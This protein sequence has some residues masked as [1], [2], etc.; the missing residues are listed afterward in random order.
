MIALMDQLLKRV[1]LDL[2]LRPYV[3]LATGADDGII[4][5]VTNSTPVSGV[6]AKFN[7]SILAYL[8]HHNPDPEGPYGVTP[9]CMSTFVKSCAGYCVITYILGVGDRH[10]DNIMLQTAGNLFHLDFGFIFGR[11][12]KPLPP[13]FRRRAIH[14][15]MWSMPPRF[16]RE[17]AEAM[18][19]E[20]SEHYA[21]FKTYMCQ[22]Y[23]WLR[24]SANLILN[25]L[26]LMADAGIEDLRNDPDATLAKVQERFRLDLTDEQAEHFMLQLLNE[27][28]TSLAPQVIRLARCGFRSRSLTRFVFSSS[29]CL[30]HGNLPQDI[31]GTE[32]GKA[33]LPW[34]G[35]FLLRDRAA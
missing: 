26:S 6:L 27:S 19:G 2:K 17:M 30:G 7:G 16:T 22:A 31:G 1:N 5:F 15:T 35:G 25:M 20:Q 10:L 4:E 13:P 33:G 8:K 28:L 3:T 18:G 29:A 14:L 9:E 11:D 24:K 32:I 21:R 12:P 34:S 23:N